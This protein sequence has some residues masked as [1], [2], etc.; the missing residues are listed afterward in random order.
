MPFYQHWGFLLVTNLLTLTLVN[1]AETSRQSLES[2]IGIDQD[3]ADKVRLFAHGNHVSIQAIYGDILPVVKEFF[4]NTEKGDLSKHAKEIK[5]YLRISEQADDMIMEFVEGAVKAIP[6]NHKA[7][8]L[9]SFLTYLIVM[10]SKRVQSKI[11]KSRATFKSGWLDE[12]LMLRKVEC[13]TIMDAVEKIVDYFTY[14]D[15][16]GV[17]ELKGD[18]R[19][20]TERRNKT[21][22]DRKIFSLLEAIYLRLLLPGK[23][24]SDIILQHLYISSARLEISVYSGVDPMTEGILIHLFVLRVVALEAAWR[25][26]TPLR[27]EPYNFDATVKRYQKAKAIIETYTKKELPSVYRT[28][29]EWT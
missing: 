18:S 15:D 8:V 2:S 26:S 23:E 13:G 25:A 28:L 17:F 10:G 4:Y 3:T 29:S 24:E 5:A 9:T 16:A 6:T 27:G 19:L 21:E 20:R 11:V 12:K 14:N 1:M 22:L 7:K